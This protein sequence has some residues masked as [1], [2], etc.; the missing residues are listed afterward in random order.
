[1]LVCPL[2]LMSKRA[3]ITGITGQDGSYLAELLLESGY[4]VF[5]VVRDECP[6]KLDNINHIKERLHLIKGDLKDLKSLT[7]AIEF[8]RPQ[9]VYNLA[10]QTAVHS[11]WGQIVET[12]EI[13]GLGVAHLLEAI[14]TVDPE[15]RFFHASSSELYGLVEE[16]PQT[17][18][19]PFRPINPY[20]TAK[21]YAHWLTSN[22][23][24]HYGMFA[25]AGILY[26]HESPRRGSNFVTR[27][28]TRGV[29]HIKL[30]LQD[31]L[32]LGNLDA[33]RDWGF[34]GDYVEAMWY[35]LQAN[36]PEDYV[37]ATGVDRSVRDFCD[38]AFAYAGLNWEEFVVIDQ[39]F[40]RAEE[41]K[42]LVG[43]NSKAREKLEWQP[44]TSF[45]EMIEEM[46]AK[47]IEAANAKTG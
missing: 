31:K 23:R 32:R 10:A 35:M 44:Q 17:E 39:S 12:G 45:K 38:A 16:S 36:S 30:G 4:E 41:G 47:D 40:Y 19:T 34:A 21:L 26:N 9:E 33:R 11:S 22:Y 42:V 13:S 6:E 29:A 37:I 43:D 5:G 20:G 46:L 25:C 2:K 28:I 14:R 27:K 24:H 8:S 1:M 15:I 7:G 18:S 3:L